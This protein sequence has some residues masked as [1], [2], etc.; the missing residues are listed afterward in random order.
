MHGSIETA[1]AAD[2]KDKAA[3]SGAFVS[4]GPFSAF[5]S[6]FCPSNSAPKVDGWALVSDSRTA[7]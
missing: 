4:E 1:A 3:A 7:F 5:Y 2:A 6:L